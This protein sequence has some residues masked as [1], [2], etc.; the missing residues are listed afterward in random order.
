MRVDIY[1]HL[2]KKVF[3]VRSREPGNYG[4]VIAHVRHAIIKNPVGVVS[5]NGRLKVLAQRKKNVHAV[6]RGE[7]ID[8]SRAAHDTINGLDLTTADGWRYN[9]YKTKEFVTAS[10]GEPVNASKWSAVILDAPEGGR[11][12]VA[13]YRVTPSPYNKAGGEA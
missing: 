2:R 3:S 5:E 6:I 4:R 11:P 1:F 7:W 12:S 10:T 9:P 13:G 8:R